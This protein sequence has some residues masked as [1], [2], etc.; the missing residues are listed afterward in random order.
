MSTT[1]T[2]MI[3][4][5]TAI[6]LFF[7]FC[8]VEIL[9]AGNPSR[10]GAVRSDGG[11][12][13]V[14]AGGITRGCSGLPLRTHTAMHHLHRCSIGLGVFWCHSVSQ[15]RSYPKLEMMGESELPTVAPVHAAGMWDRAVCLSQCTPWESSSAS[16]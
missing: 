14:P 15:Q 16:P 9:T 2:K 5:K 10:C 11:L 12:R 4:S 6:L 7:L 13:A 3:C 8:N 1:Q